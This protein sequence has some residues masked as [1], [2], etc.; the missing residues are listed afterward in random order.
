MFIEIDFNSRL[1]EMINSQQRDKQRTYFDMF[2]K[3]GTKLK[4]DLQFGN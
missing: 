1:D 3:L 4:F 2:Y